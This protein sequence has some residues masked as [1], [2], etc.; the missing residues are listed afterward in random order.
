MA[1]SRRQR[2]RTWHDV[3]LFYGGMFLLF[4]FA[5]GLPFVMFI[6]GSDSESDVFKEIPRI[7][8]RALLV[9][10]ETY[11]TICA[12]RLYLFARSVEAAD[13]RRGGVAD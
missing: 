2:R 7:G 9:L 13:E 11:F 5:V 12:A 1:G 3:L 6:A 4:V 10:F 8:S